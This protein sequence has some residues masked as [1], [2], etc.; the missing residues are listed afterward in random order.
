MAKTAK[1]AIRHSKP[2]ANKGS[3]YTDEHRRAAIGMFLVTGNYKETAKRLNM[4]DTTIHNWTKSEWW[5]NE[6]AI[7]RAEK[8]DELDAMVSNSINK[9]IK[10]VDDR[11]ESGDAY[12]IAKTGEVG[13]KP[14]SARDSATV[15]GILYDKRQ[16]MRLLPTTITAS[17]DNDKLLK[18]QQSFEQLAAAK[19]KEIEA[20]IVG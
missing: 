1:K 15:L 7:V 9:A 4:P 11:L 2:L 13:Y 14:V 16:I 19:T 10:S 8:S 3:K 20:S 17:T 5:L 6:I 12:V 18:L